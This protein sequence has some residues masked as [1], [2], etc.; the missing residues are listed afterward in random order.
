MYNGLKNIPSIERI[1]FQ[2]NST[3]GKQI[4]AL[5]QEVIDYA[6]SSRQYMNGKAKEVTRSRISE[7]TDWANSTIVTRLDRLI[8]SELN[9]RTI[10]VI[11][12]SAVYMNAYMIPMWLDKNG[13]E[14][15]DM[16][17][18]AWYRSDVFT[19]TASY[20]KYTDG[21][22]IDIYNETADLIDIRIGKL[23][24]VPKYYRV[25]V[26]IPIGIFISEE[27]VDEYPSITAA[28]ITAVILH[29]LGHGMTILE[30]IADFYYRADVAKNA[31][32]YTDTDKQDISKIVTV[33]ERASNDNTTD[34]RLVAAFNYIKASSDDKS[35]G[36]IT[37]V[38]AIFLPYIIGWLLI[39][40]LSRTSALI[41]AWA[42]SIKSSDTLVNKSNVAYMERI[43]DEFVARFGY[44]APLASGL[45]KAYMMTTGDCIRG[46]SIL[47]MYYKI[48]SMIGDFLNCPLYDSFLT[49]DQ[50]SRRLEHMLLN[51]YVVF[52]DK[53]LDPKVQKY[54]IDETKKIQDTITKYKNRNS[55]KIKDLFW[56][57][58]TRI[59]S[60]ASLVKT[61]VD[62]NLQSDYDKLQWLTGG[63]IKNSLYYLA[64]RLRNID[65]K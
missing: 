38:L 61:F 57:T 17:W 55:E 51:N 22:Y 62:A 53:N 8:L 23:K 40:V 13:K 18:D 6:A 41:Q 33:L 3:F 34:S 44:S 58:I 5:M 60:G 16:S 45:A 48:T 49:Y 7:L 24:S 59:T 65:T 64:A 31:I 20:E 19:G 52:K 25:D 12:E 42:P 27:L 15:D 14:S 47:K 36:Y 2:T 54:F 43:A 39:T 50:P 11:D 35:K 37:A 30:C 46:I 10:S 29:E 1:A 4:E 63:L 21:K 28:E 56:N 32:T 9:L 26:H